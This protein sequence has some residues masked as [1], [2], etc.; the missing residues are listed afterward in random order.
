MHGV[1]TRML[2]HQ[3][4]DE[5]NGDRAEAARRVGVGRTTMYRWIKAG[6]L[7]QPIETIQARYQSR[8]PIPTK[9]EKYTALIEARLAEF[10][11]L[12]GTRLLAECRAAGY[13]G[14][15]TQLRAYAQR[16]RPVPT[17]DVVRFETEP[18]Q[19]AQIDWAHCRLPWGVRYALVIVLGYS[20]LLWLQF[21][22]RQDLAT[23]ILGLE[24]VLPRG[25]ARS[26]ISYSTK[27]DRSSRATID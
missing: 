4:L 8:P 24:A 26:K 27:C 19:Q 20:R 17:E 1:L 18:G 14:G 3:L 16:L 25:A 7:D 5:A 2:L 10:P 22:P 12:S 23:L 13:T 6:L 21:Y 9:L 11:R 15:V